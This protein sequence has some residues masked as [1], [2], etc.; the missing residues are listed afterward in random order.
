MMEHDVS[1]GCL[2][3]FRIDQLVAAELAPGIARAARDHLAGCARCRT[4]LAAVESERE[5]FASAPPPPIPAAVTLGA[6]TAP[7]RNP[8]RLWWLAAPAL[9]AAAVLV[10]VARPR[11]RE[12][13]EGVRTKGAG[14]LELFVE[15]GGA[16]RAAE[17]REVVAPGDRLQLAYSTSQAQFLAIVGVDTTGSAEVYYPSS[18]TAAPISTGEH[19]TIDRSIVLD[20][21]PGDETIYGLFCARPVALGAALDELR[22]RAQVNGCTVETLRLEKRVA[23]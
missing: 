19:V 2:S 5:V 23:R 3:S 22:A 4:R 13:S 14:H 9:V 16:I 17:P 15:H 7:S 20:E 8:R 18:D 21:T 1:E 12:D 6:R 10:W 11:A